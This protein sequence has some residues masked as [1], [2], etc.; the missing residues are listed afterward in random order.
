M[1]LIEF[2]NRVKRNPET[3]RLWARQGILKPRKMGKR[4]DYVFSPKDLERAKEW[5]LWRRR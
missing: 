3:V 2:A 1:K 5:V 4:G